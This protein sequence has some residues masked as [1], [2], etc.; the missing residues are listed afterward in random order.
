MK[1]VLLLLLLIIYTTIFSQS[2]EELCSA[3]KISFYERLGKSF[4]FAYPG[5]SNIDITYY[6]LDLN[7]TYSPQYLRG[8]VTVKCKSSVVQINS[9]FLDL[10]SGFKVNS[11]KTGNQQLSFSLTSDNKLSINLGRP[12]QLNE[13]FIL[14]IDYEGKPNTSGGIG[15]SF[16]FN[17]TPAGQ[18]VIWTL[19][20]PYGSQDWWPSKDTPADKADSSDVWITAPSSFVSVSNGTLIETRNNGNGTLTYKWKNNYPIANYLISIAM[21][22]YYLYQT[23]FEYEPG[24]TFSITH[25]VYPESYASQKANLDRTNDM[26]RI[27]SEMFG[28]YPYPKEKYG[29]AQ[30]GFGGGMEHQTISSMG[31]FSESLIAHELAHQW[32]GDKVTCKDWQNIWLNEGFATYS[33]KLYHQKKYGDVTFLSQMN[34]VM[35]SAKTASGT[36]YVQNINSVSEIFS[37]SRS[38]NKGATVLHMLRGI[39]GDDNFFR[40]LKEYLA[41]PG[42]SYNVA[43]TQDFQRIAE[44]VSGQ[45][46]NYFF[47]QWI[48]GAGYPKYTFGWRAEQ[49]TGNSYNLIVRVKQQSNSNPLFFTMPLQIYYSTPF[50]TKTITVFN[51]QQE[52]GWVIPVNGNPNSVLLDPNNW[53]LKDIVGYTSLAEEVLPEKFQL[54]QNYPN[55]FNPITVI[56]YQ[57]SVG[58]HIKLKIYDALGTEVA[59][60]VDEY[61]QPGS[62]KYEWRI[63]SRGLPSSEARNGELTS[64]IYFYK[65]TAV[66]FSQTKKMIYLK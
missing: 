37:P 21:S 61:Q 57:L 1:K 19:S 58:S 50:E 2:G 53:I 17:V 29:H 20:Q 9:L 33:D 55:P 26:I 35:S 25:Y 5:D 42:L 16:V 51:D 54:F 10:W 65:L 43:V 39:I 30:C 18:P 14:V 41:E 23:Q 31:V 4:E 47:Q 48:Y 38:Y 40:T 64:G 63:D 44:R 32:F 6:K 46:L 36:I 28:P 22:N 3:S 15:G 13:E 7:I 66:N 62:Y 52:Q 12:Y 59:T 45:N 11:V 24:K 8:V 27:Y 34:S 60:L 49:V 56:S